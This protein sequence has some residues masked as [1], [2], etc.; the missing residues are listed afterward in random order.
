MESV[1]K[2]EEER[3]VVTEGEEGKRPQVKRIDHKAAKKLHSTLAKELI[4]A[5][6]LGEYECQ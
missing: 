1:V 2:P 4:S 3:K 6:T 5:L